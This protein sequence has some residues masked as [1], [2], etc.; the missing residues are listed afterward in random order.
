M[1]GF[2]T[3]VSA[4]L[5]C[6]QAA[7]AGNLDGTWV[8]KTDRSGLAYV[9]EGNRYVAYFNGQPQDRGAIYWSGN[10]AL[11]LD[12]DFGAPYTYGARY[13]GKF[14]NVVDPA[15][16]SHPANFWAYP[17]KFWRSHKADACERYKDP[18]DYWSC[19][20]QH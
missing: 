7:L 15:T 2:L 8:S 16:V 14:L 13:D 19:L 17:I 20:R 12:S 9:V 18:M 11:T 5:L 1:K 10:D 3:A 6:C 4:A